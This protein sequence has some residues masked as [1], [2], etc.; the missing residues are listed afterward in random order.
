MV[1]GMITAA[2]MIRV[3]NLQYEQERQRRL[4]AERH[5]ELETIAALWVKSRNLRL[6]L[7]EC[8]NS[9]SASAVAPSDDSQARWLR[10]ALAY[11]DSVDPLKSG[12]LQ[13]YEAWTIQS[14]C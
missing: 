10:W 7:E 3:K 14:G 12:E 2:E 13:T 11:A 6:F 1:V 8:E 9:L 4:E 5:P